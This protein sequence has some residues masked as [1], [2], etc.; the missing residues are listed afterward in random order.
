MAGSRTDVRARLLRAALDLFSERGF[1]GTTA[2]AIAERANVTERTYFRHFPDKREAL[3]DGEDAL[4]RDLA[5]AIANVSV[6]LTPMATL[7][8]AF[9]S[10][11]PSFESDRDLKRRRQVVIAAAPALRERELTKEQRLVT[12]VTLALEERQ[13]RTPVAS[14]VAACGIA[15]LSRVRLE[16][17]GGDPRDYATLL[18][19][20]FADLRT[21][22]CL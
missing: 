4:Q 2:A 20:A 18:S 3:F 16:W 12:C 22:L 1:D 5:G 14:L 6:G 9:L 7:L 21:A 11:A 10:M 8:E 13:V 17:L 15:V 19:E